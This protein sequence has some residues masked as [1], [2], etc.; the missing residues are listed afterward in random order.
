MNLL[1][2]SRDVSLLTED[3]LCAKKQAKSRQ[4]PSQLDN[5]RLA[6]FFS[7]QVCAASEPNEC[8]MYKSVVYSLILAS[9]CS[10]IACIVCINKQTTVVGVHAYFS[11][12]NHRQFP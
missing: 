8:K 1:L 4:H 6:V 2:N 3:E 7:V 5:E 10:L 12:L 9:K 11:H